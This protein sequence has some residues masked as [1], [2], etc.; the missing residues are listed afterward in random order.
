[1]IEVAKISGETVIVNADHIDT[2][3]TTP[4][5][6]LVL[7]SGKKIMVLDRPSDIMEKIIAYKRRVFLNLPERVRKNVALEND[8][9]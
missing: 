4:D 5:T 1:M 9:V 8:K 6:M 7:A 2:I 3:E